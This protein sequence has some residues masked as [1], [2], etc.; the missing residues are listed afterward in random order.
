MVDF[1]ERMARIEGNLEQL[2]HRFTSLE[3][4]VTH[5][6]TQIKN[7]LDTQFKWVIGLE[8]SSLAIILMAILFR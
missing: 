8:I 5:R 6:L 3:N 1:G 2:N 7:R 4:Q